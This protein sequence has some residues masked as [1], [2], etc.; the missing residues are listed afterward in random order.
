MTRKRIAGFTGVSLATIGFI[1]M[2]AAYASAA[3]KWDDENC[4]DGASGCPSICGPPPGT[5]ILGTVCN[6]RDDYWFSDGTCCWS[7][8][9]SPDTFLI[10]AAVIVL[11]TVVLTSL[12]L[13]CG[14]K[15]CCEC[16][17]KCTAIIIGINDVVGLIFV[18]IIF[19]ILGATED[20]S[21]C[22][23]TTVY[24]LVGVNGTAIAGTVFLLLGSI[25]ACVVTFI[26][27]C[28]DDSPDVGGATTST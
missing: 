13:E 25:C 16:C 24:K 28:C 15:I 4:C 5:G 10:I 1:I 18:I 9:D 8:N 21:G 7:V 6:S 2:I 23:S 3:G 19:V 26:E 12:I 11:V 17:Q 14:D 20:S 22:D 27:C